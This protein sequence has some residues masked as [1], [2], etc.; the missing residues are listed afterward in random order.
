MAA[1]VAVLTTKNYRLFNR[2]DEN[3]NLILKKHKRL[4][5][6]MRQYGF[7]DCFPIVCFSNSNG[8]LVVKD[9]Q[10]RL[11]IAEELGLPV[12][13]IVTERDF[14][15]ATTNSGTVNWNMLDYA[16]RWIAKGHKNYQIGLE[17]AARYGLPLGVSFGMLAGT[18]AYTNVESEFK[19]GTYKIKDVAWAESVAGLYSKLLAF[20]PL[21]L[22]NT[23]FLEACM[24]VCRLPEF[25]SNRMIRCAE[26][27][28]DQLVAYSNRD[29]FLG[30]LEAVYNHGQKR[31]VPLK[32]EAIQVMRD[33]CAVKSKPLPK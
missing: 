2:S 18:A 4:Y 16:N 31:M 10:H 19:D 22:R 17:F 5:G 32:V 3:R 15:V 28:R 21:Q 8:L 1:K 29:A 24:A 26:R 7:L 13:Y 30:M 12:S 27:C 20:A 11:A 23:R 14:D 6:S 25:D 33:R 9:G